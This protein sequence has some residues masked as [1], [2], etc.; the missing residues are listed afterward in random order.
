[1]ERVPGELEHLPGDRYPL[2]LGA[3][4]RENL[5]APDE[6]EIAVAQHP[7]GALVTWRRFG[8]RL[9][10]AHRC[11]LCRTRRQIVAGPRRVWSQPLAFPMREPAAGPPGSGWA[12]RRQP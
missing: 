6:A 3:D 11:R 9:T 5:R 12:T 8:G 1:M 2:N 10:C 7:E 4:L